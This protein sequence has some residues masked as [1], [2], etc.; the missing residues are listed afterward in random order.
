MLTHFRD[1][2]QICRHLCEFKNKSCLLFG[3]VLISEAENV[4]LEKFSSRLSESSQTDHFETTT[5]TL[6]VEAT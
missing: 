2:N 4:E 1:I 3:I 6:H 5:A